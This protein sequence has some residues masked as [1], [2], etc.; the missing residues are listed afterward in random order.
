MHKQKLVGIEFL[1]IILLLCTNY[2]AT[3]NSG[4]KYLRPIFNPYRK[5]STDLQGVQNQLTYLWQKFLIMLVSNVKPIDFKV[6]TNSSPFSK[7]DEI[8][9][10]AFIQGMELS[11]FAPPP[12]I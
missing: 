11:F 7:I 8:R 1:F 4:S 9:Q 12:Y 10:L 2:F 5:E 6:S 3:C